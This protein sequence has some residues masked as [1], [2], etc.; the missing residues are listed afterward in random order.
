MYKNI[1]IIYKSQDIIIND[2]SEQFN[3][4]LEEIN[5]EHHSKPSNP[6]LNGT[7]DKIINISKLLDKPENEEKIV[8]IVSDRIEEHLELEKEKKKKTG[9]LEK[10]IKAHT[11][12]IEANSL[13]SGETQK[14]GISE[15]ISNIDKQL[16]KLKEWISE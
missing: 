6:L 1:P 13:I 8:E 11:A 10:I 5:N 12:L 15:Q 14:H 7:Q 9:V 2:I 4:E 16:I 3:E